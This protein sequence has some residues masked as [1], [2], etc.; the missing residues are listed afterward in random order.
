ME[1]IILVDGT[2]VTESEY[3]KMAYKNH[4][5]DLYT[6]QEGVDQTN[7]LSMTEHIPSIVTN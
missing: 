3:I 7:I 4:F 2:N 6:Q 1:N 5:V